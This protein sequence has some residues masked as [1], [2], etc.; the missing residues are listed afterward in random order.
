MRLNNYFSPKLLSESYF[1]PCIDPPNHELNFFKY[2]KAIDVSF[3]M[4]KFLH[5]IIIPRWTI[6]MAIIIPKNPRIYIFFTHFCKNTKYASGT[7]C[8][9]SSGAK[10]CFTTPCMRHRSLL[11]SCQQAKLVKARYIWFPRTDIFEWG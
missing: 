1:V 7:N 2:I 9:A 5:P 3:I 11:L 10:G 6:E 8:E 4:K